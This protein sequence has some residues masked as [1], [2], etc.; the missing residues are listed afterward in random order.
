MTQK[1]LTEFENGKLQG[2]YETISKLLN[3]AEAF[4][5]VDGLPENLCSYC[6]ED[7]LRE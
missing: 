3:Q 1:P 4:G 7:L 6:P 5:V 2:Y